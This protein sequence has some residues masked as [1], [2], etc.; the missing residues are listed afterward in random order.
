MKN[1]KKEI[2]RLIGMLRMPEYLA[3][4]FRHGKLGTEELIHIMV[5]AE[6]NCQVPNKYFD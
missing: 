3:D 2:D 1:S 4:K 5:L 6:Q